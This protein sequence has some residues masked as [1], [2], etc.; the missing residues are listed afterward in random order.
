MGEVPSPVKSTV[1]QAASEQTCTCAESVPEATVKRSTGRREV[2]TVSVSGPTRRGGMSVQFALG[3]SQPFVSF[4]SQFEKP[5]VHVIRQADATQLGVEFA[6]VGHTLPHAP[7][8][9]ALVVVVISHPS[10]Y[11]PLQSP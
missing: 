7:Q 3:V 5:E 10:E 8:F 6:R 11:V 1:E 4:A 9:V 2:T